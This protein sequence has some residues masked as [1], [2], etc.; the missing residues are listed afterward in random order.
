MHHVRLPG[1]DSFTWAPGDSIA[2]D[3]GLSKKQF[4][5]VSLF[6]GLDLSEADLSLEAVDLVSRIAAAED[7][8]HRERREYIDS[9][10]R[11]LIPRLGAT[12][13]KELLVHAYNEQVARRPV[14]AF[15]RFLEGLRAKFEGIDTGSFEELLRFSGAI[16]PADE[17]FSMIHVRENLADVIYHRESPALHNSIRESLLRLFE[18]VP[19]FSL[20][21]LP[22][23]ISST[24][25]E[26]F[27]AH[28]QFDMR[29]SGESYGGLESA[30]YSSLLVSMVL[31]IRPIDTDAVY[32]LML[33]NYRTHT[34]HCPVEFLL[35]GLLHSYVNLTCLELHLLLL[36]VSYLQR[37]RPDPVYVDILRDLLEKC[38]TLMRLGALLGVNRSADFVDLV[39]TATLC[40]P[41]FSGDLAN[42][43]IDCTGMWSFCDLKVPWLRSATPTEVQL[44]LI[45]Y[46]WPGG[47][48]LSFGGQPRGM[49]GSDAW[50]TLHWSGVHDPDTLALFEAEPRETEETPLKPV[51]M[52]ARFKRLRE[53]RPDM[54][55]EVALDLDHV[56]R[57]P[58]TSQPTESSP[59]KEFLPDNIVHLS[60]D[61]VPGW[62][63]WE[64]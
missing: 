35:V 61:S 9:L 54:M 10:L 28:F 13:A 11:K 63:T 14:T 17:K 30:E 22:Q 33:G 31:G 57:P 32:K 49:V 45:S 4:G 43:T 55:L 21:E 25:G 56:P 6:R 2:N 44:P 60:F 36:S 41:T 5:A 3:L 50:M 12:C 27:S 24:E 51:L 8:A 29:F 34:S 37:F 53:G 26:L 59:Q 58:K 62:D 16:H 23:S 1:E 47:N 40:C 18:R 20:D 46:R 42:A 39:L 64:V 52:N 19:E 15:A 38:K 7:L 48:L